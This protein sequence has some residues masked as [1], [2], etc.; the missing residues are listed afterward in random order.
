VLELLLQRV[1]LTVDEV[2]R[3]LRLT[4]TAVVTH[5]GALLSE[6]L[7]QR[8]GV[9][10]GKRRPS[11][12]YSL[13]KDADRLFPQE[14]DKLAIGIIDELKRSNAGKLQA[15]LQRAAERWASRDLAS[16][17]NMEGSARVDRATALLSD[18]GL[19]PLIER[20][21]RG[22]LLR[23]YHCPLQRVGSLHP[24]V[25]VIIKRSIQALF[26]KP[27]KRLGCMSL[28]N[29]HCAYAIGRVPASRSNQPLHG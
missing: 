2:A 28:G 24:E 7:A 8:V 14:Y 6:G 15:V 13:T 21:G 16:L 3:E 10:A 23:Q 12:L 29:T 9:R 20:A 25:C 4:R 26:G 17:R 19:M 11:A 27:V 5:L 18:R 22:Y 1:T